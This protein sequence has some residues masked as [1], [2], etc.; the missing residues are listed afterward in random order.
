DVLY[1]VVP[2]E[3]RF[4]IMTNDQAENFKLMQCPLDKTTV[5]HWKEIIPHRSDVLLESVE[6]FKDFLVITE[7]FNG[8]TRL[9]I[10]NRKTKEEKLVS[11]D[12]P[13]Y[14]VYPSGNE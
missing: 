10:Q 9:V 3:D 2:L 14:V 6:E 4:L 7:R 5:E 12:D 1:S 8:L 13:T 11:F